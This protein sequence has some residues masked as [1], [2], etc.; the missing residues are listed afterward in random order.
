MNMN[1]LKRIFKKSQPTKSFDQIMDDPELRAI[2]EALDYTIGTSFDQMMY[3]PDLRAI[4][5]ALDHPGR[6]DP[7]SPNANTEDE[8]SDE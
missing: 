3:D 1:W 2:A 6:R 7:R 8:P 4:A 5:D